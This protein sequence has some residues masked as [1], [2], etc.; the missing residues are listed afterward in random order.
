MNKKITCF[1]EMLWD[2]FPNGSIPGGA[3]MNVALHLHYL[4][5]EVDFISKIGQDQEG[6]KLLRF[7]NEFGLPTHAIQTSQS[8]PTGKVLVNDGDKENIQYE[9]VRPAAWDEIAWSE[10]LQEKVDRSDALLFGSLAARE[11]TSRNTLFQLLKTNTL[12]VCDINLRAPFYSFEVLQELLSHTDLLKVNEEELRVLSSFHQWSGNTEFLLDKLTGFYALDLVCVTL[13]KD[14]ALLYY[15]DK[16][17]PHPGYPVTVQ[18]TVGSG[19]AFLSMFIHSYLMN[20]AP[21]QLLDDACALGALVATH[22]GGTPQYSLGD[23]EN[24]KKG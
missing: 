22:K 15:E 20:K 10:T 24:I 14:G 18:D 2:I 17:I 19:D 16:L 12:K 3:P 7:L 4:G 6:Q 5:A 13:G 8:L 9:I 21:E 11:E 23:I 1:G